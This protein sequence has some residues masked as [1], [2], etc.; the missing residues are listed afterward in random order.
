MK[1]LI[2]QVIH[3]LLENALIGRS[4]SVSDIIEHTGCKPKTAQKL[5]KIVTDY[6]NTKKFHSWLEFFNKYNKH[7]ELYIEPDFIS[8]RPDIVLIN[9]KKK[10]IVIIDIK[11][12]DRTK[13]KST[14]ILVQL[15]KYYSMLKK[16]YHNY[17]ITMY[18]FWAKLG[19]FEVFT[20]LIAELYSSVDR[21]VN[22][23]Y[24]QRVGGKS[25]VE[26]QKPAESV[27]MYGV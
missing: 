13:K 18:I 25:Y 26:G 4:V 1:Y 8:I 17:R 9:H 15:F 19:E 3:L 11:T 16:H 6:R 5:I 10:R 22:R 27:T 7:W 21:Y 24:K 2:G 23:Q 14:K 12:G 20:H